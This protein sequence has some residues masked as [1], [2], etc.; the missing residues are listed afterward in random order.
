MQQNKFA[1][2]I[3]IYNLYIMNPYNLV[4]IIGQSWA[5]KI[6]Q[7]KVSYILVRRDYY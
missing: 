4:Y 3:Q 1:R 6:V 5:S 7:N 2:E